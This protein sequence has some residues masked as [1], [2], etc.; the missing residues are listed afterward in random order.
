MST[1]VQPSPAPRRQGRRPGANETR[2][3]ILDAARTRFA[4]DGYAGSTIRK[5]AGDAGVDPS[6][7]MQFF[8]SKE[9]LFR[10]VM[11]GTPSALS[12]ISEAFEGPTDTLGQRV[13]RAFLAVWDSGSADSE[14]FH[15][16]LRAAIGNEH[17]AEQLRE[18]IQTRLIDDLDPRLRE[19]PD[20]VIRVQVVSSMLIGVIVGR[21]IVHVDALVHE[22][23][24][25]LI[26]LI[27]PAVQAIL[28]ADPLQ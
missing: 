6:L 4:K 27:A 15:A 5:I 9:D 25:S 24:E 23:R 11:A 16:M 20:T 17:A 2:V 1:P 10:E 22:D 12:R 18:L 7:V 8:G 26:A 19:R 14:P 21:R 3:A 28:V 13:T